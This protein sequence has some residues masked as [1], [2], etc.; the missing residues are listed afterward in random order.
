MSSFPEDL[1]AEASL[2]ATLGNGGFHPNALDVLT[3]LSS[4]DFM[5]PTHK[6]I[7]KALTK[8]YAADTDVN[9]LTI[10]AQLEA[11]GN[12][13]KANGF[14]GLTDV[15]GSE[16]LGRPFVLAKILKEKTLARKVL[17]ISMEAAEKVRDSV[18]PAQDILAEASQLLGALQAREPVVSKSSLEHAELAAAGKP[19]LEK[20]NQRSLVRFGIPSIDWK[21]KGMPGSLGV[22]AA[23]TSAGKTSLLIQ[24]LL[25]SERPALL[26]LEMD[27][28]EVDARL[29]A[30]YSGVEADAIVNGTAGK[31]DILGTPEAKEMLG[32]IGKVCNWDNQS[33][34]AIEATIISLARI[35]HMT[36]FVDYWTLIQIGVLKGNSIS[37]TLGEISR[38]FKALA[39]RLGIAII[40]V[41]QFNREVKDGERPTL[42]NLRETGQLEQDANWILMMWT[43][44]PTYE[45]GDIR[46]VFCELQ[47]NRGGARWV[48]ARTLFTPWTSQFREEAKDT[49]PTPAKKSLW[50]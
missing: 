21:I 33:Y 32:S 16:E 23:K 20:A 46:T 10:K 18:A 4:E 5:D 3:G 8:L 39:K 44:K 22:M 9:L 30:C 37:F 7:H 38:N 15:M 50:E 34:S 28:W 47:K 42:E 31:I 41:S 1:K 19:L 43:E 17:K 36:F 49:N 40:L 24:A 35:G 29:L 11:D 6:V 2:L 13:K 45:P 27:D 14:L 26:S 25:H 12:L 48:K